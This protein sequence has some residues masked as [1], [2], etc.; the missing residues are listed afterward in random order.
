[1]FILPGLFCALAVLSACQH[2]ADRNNNPITNAKEA[3]KDRDIQ[4]TFVG[5]CSTA[6]SNDPGTFF[7]AL[8]NGQVVL[9]SAQISYQISG[10]NIYR[11]NTYFSSSDC[12]KD[13]A[14]FSTEEL[15]EKNT[16]DEKTA[17]NLKLMTIDWKHLFVTIDSDNGATYAN[18]YK[19][20][21]K[22]SWKVG[23]NTKVDETANKS[24]CFKLD[25]AK[26]KV[27]YRVD[28][29]QLSLTEMGSTTGPTEEYLKK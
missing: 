1:L 8:L 14:I 17:G 7:S 13:S 16:T 9:K 15:G 24:T 19:L 27:G 10:V 29:S 12:H 22:T 26:N 25:K 28:N 2:S 23:E 4:G 21:D 18:T 3:S 6:I 11:K 5:K 20:C